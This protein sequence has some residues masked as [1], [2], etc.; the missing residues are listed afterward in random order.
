MSVSVYLAGIFP[1]LFT[2]Y[3]APSIVSDQFWVSQMVSE[4]LKVIVLSHYF[5]TLKA[6]HKVFAIFIDSI[7]Y[8]CNVHFAGLHNDVGQESF[9]LLFSSSSSVL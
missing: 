1:V 3:T 7:I 8:L 5:P 6:G 4:F 2:E 9:L